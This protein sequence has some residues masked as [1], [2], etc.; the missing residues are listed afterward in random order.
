MGSAR[1][2]RG[3]PSKRR[4]WVLASAPP[5]RD[6]QGR[7]RA[8]TALHRSPRRPDEARRLLP[9]RAGRGGRGSHNS[10]RAP[11]SRREGGRPPRLAPRCRERTG[12]ALQPLLRAR[13]HGG[14]PLAPPR[15]PGRRASPWVAAA[16]CHLLAGPPARPPGTRPAPPLAAAHRAEADPGGWLRRHL[17]WATKPGPASAAARLGGYESAAGFNAPPTSGAE[18]TTPGHTHSFPPRAKAN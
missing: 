11:Q 5:S 14:G 18:P 10:C 7:T 3:M 16:H 17:E 12:R 9:G 6:R 2:G 1:K 4:R 13:R 8:G 15:P